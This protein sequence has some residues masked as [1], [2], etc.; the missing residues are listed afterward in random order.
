MAVR[1]YGVTSRDAKAGYI[2]LAV[3]VGTRT[4]YSGAYSVAP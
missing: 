2:R 3:K 4:Y 1:P